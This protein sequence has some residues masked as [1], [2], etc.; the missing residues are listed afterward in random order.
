MAEGEARLYSL[1]LPVPHVVV[2]DIDKDTFDFESFCEGVFTA[3]KLFLFL[4]QAF[5]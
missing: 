4:L 1:G 5:I 2:E 3:S